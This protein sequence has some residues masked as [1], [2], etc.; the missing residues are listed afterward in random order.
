MKKDMKGLFFIIKGQYRR[1][2]SGDDTIGYDPFNPET[3]EWYMLIDNKTFTCISCGGD[4]QKVLKSVYKV[5][6]RHKG[7][8]NR[9]FKQ[10]SECESKVSKTS[11]DIYM[12]VYR[13]FGD[14]FEDQV[15]EM[16]DL[17]YEE[18]KQE[19]SVF[20]SQKLLGKHKQ[21]I[22]VT[23]TPLKDKVSTP[24]PLVKPKKVLGI[25]RLARV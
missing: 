14:Y 15:S 5:I 2:R 13:E 23:T 1:D 17:A 11:Q 16:E 25:K 19:Q 22:G 10:V 12:K 7:I 8:A 9:Y 6:K 21:H 24:L 20:K 18:L 3:P 4:L